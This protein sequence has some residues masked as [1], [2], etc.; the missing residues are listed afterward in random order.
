MAL[1]IF[2]QESKYVNNDLKFELGGDIEVAESNLHPHFR[3][4]TSTGR[5]TMAG[6]ADTA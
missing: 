2:I 3:F 1:I 5:T 4:E 6:E